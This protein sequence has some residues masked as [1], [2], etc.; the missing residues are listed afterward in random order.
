[1]SGKRKIPINYLVD[2]FMDQQLITLNRNK[3]E[4]KENDADADAK[5]KKK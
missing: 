5:T 3:K 1:M 4:E 2:E